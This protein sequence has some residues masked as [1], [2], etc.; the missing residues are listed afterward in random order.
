MIQEKEHIY[1]LQTKNRRFYNFDPTTL[2]VG[3][4]TNA[5]FMEYEPSG[6]DEMALQNI[7]N[8]RYWGVD[9][10][11]SIPFTYVLDGAGIVK[12][13]FYTLG[14]E[15]D[16]YLSISRRTLHFQPGVGYGFWYE[17][18]YFGQLDLSTFE[19][20]GEGVSCST[21]EDGLVKHLKANENT[22]YDYPALPGEFIWVK[23]DGLNLHNKVETFVSNGDSLDVDF[24]LGNHLIAGA[25]VAEDAPYVSGKKD[26]ERIKVENLNSSIRATEG[27][28]FKSTI[29]GTVFLDFD[30]EVDM[31]F[32]GGAITP[33]AEWSF[34]VRRID[35]ANF[36]DLSVVLYH[37]D[38]LEGPNR[39]TRKVRIKGTGSIVVRPDDELYLYAFSNVTGAGGSDAIRVNY[40]MVDNSY[41]KYT[42]KYR[43][44]TSYVKFFRPQVLFSK[45]IAS[46]T[47]AQYAAV[48]SSYLNTHKNIVFTS[49]RFL[50]GIADSVAQYSIS[51]FFQFW[52]CFD[53]ASL[54][55]KNG[56]VDLST[57]KLLVDPTVWIDLPEPAYKTPKISLDNE[58]LF[59]EVE[60]GYQDSGSEIGI[61][62]GTEDVHTNILFSIGTTNK[63][64]RIDKVS[65]VNASP[66]NIE[67]IRVSTY[68]KDT[69][70]N[71]AD[72]EPFVV[73]IGNVLQPAVGDIPAHY[74]LD[75]TLNPLATGII[76]A[77]TTYNLYLTPKRNL[78]RNGPFL[79][80]CTWLLDARLLEFK[81]SKRTVDLLCDG[82]QEK[83]SIA[84]GSLGDQ[85]FVPLLFAAEFEITEAI[86]AAL[87][88]NPLSVVRFPFQGSYFKG[89]L[90]KNDL[91]PIG[92]A[93]K[94][95]TILLL[96]NNDIHKLINYYG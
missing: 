88:D 38:Q 96:N 59:N 80:S 73:H 58:M 32:L 90:K 62:N 18:I 74:L 40:T 82:I 35:Q 51:D 84:V 10:T 47:D 60:V 55:E 25:I 65:Y 5:Y 34:V 8:K 81:S 85:F 22:K 95:F 68:Q 7:R 86:S 43:H 52:D 75:R 16:I 2:Q 21:A 37:I 15:A 87:A 57:K 41:F 1:A 94:N 50:R 31:S 24:N 61:L 20:V 39:F 29:D 67:R 48:Q 93:N 23:M 83:Q 63:P 3:L 4:S 77:A 19:H 64:A 28:F 11:V 27:W 76:E 53:S 79:R 45:L 26:T 33:G 91:P 13:A 46:S 66:Y 89:I 72:N 78:L 69:T 92:S 36:S 70:E 54:T 71:E 12:N 42:Y 49:G 6:W 44:P 56:L 9:M 17:E 30:F 14:A